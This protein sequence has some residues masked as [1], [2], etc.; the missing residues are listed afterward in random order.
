ML[1]QEKEAEQLPPLKLLSGKIIS[2][3]AASLM[4][5]LL[6]V[7]HLSGKCYI[8]YTSCSDL[9]FAAKLTDLVENFFA[10]LADVSCNAALRFHFNEQCSLSFYLTFSLQ[11]TT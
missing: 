3:T 10:S 2:S 11:N 1:F 4:N 5:I 6:S 7:V 8:S 9:S